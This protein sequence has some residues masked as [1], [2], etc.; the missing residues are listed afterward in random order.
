MTSAYK[1][2]II[3][4]KSEKARLRATRGWVTRHAAMA[5]RQPSPEDEW[6][7]ERRK[8]VL[9]KIITITDPRSGETIRLQLWNGRGARVNQIS[10]RTKGKPWKALGR[11]RLADSLA[12]FLTS[13][14]RP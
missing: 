5:A 12:K 7:R 2:L 1:R 3:K 9:M 6:Q 10:V 14:E 11:T 8:A 13:A 4:R